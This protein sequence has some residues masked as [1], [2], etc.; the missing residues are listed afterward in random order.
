M[1]KSIQYFNSSGKAQHIPVPDINNDFKG[2]ILI[3]E[4]ESDIHVC[5]HAHE[6][7]CMRNIPETFFFL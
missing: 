5:M 7:I 6:C 3:W 4:L 2:Q 1:T